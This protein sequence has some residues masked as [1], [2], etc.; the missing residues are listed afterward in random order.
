MLPNLSHLVEHNPPHGS[1]LTLHITLFGGDDHELLLS[2]F[3]VRENITI[4]E[5]FREYEDRMERFPRSL[6]ESYFGEEKYRMATEVAGEYI[7]G[8]YEGQGS[9][10]ELKHRD[11]TIVQVTLG[12]V[13]DIFER[14]GMWKLEGIVKEPTY[15]GSTPVGKELLTR[16]K[17][18]FQA[19]NKIYVSPHPGNTRWIQTLREIEYMYPDFVEVRPAV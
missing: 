11:A 14:N 5:D 4:L 6:Y 18:V 3:K 2:A 7:Q 15:K 1:P 19:Q 9:F 10:L 12:N 8:R 13:L 17:D 16:L